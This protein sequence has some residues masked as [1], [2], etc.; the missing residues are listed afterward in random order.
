MKND[1]LKYL[2]FYVQVTGVKKKQLVITKWSI[3]YLTF[4]D[5]IVLLAP[6]LG[7]NAF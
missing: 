2:G 3:V 7:Q 5:K 4:I 6:V 1:V